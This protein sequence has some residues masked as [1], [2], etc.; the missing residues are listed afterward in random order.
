MKI[1]NFSLKGSIILKVVSLLLISSLLASCSHNKVIIAHRGA[2]GVLPEHTLQGV[3]M[4]HAWGVDFIEPDVVLSR[5]SEAIVLHDIYLESTTNVKE[6]FPKRARSDGHYYAIDFLLEEIKKLQVNERINPKTGLK[7]YPKRFPVKKSSFKVPTLKEYIELVQGLNK[8][9]GQNIGIYPEIKRPSFHKLEGKDITSIV[10]KI[11]S[12]YGYENGN[13]KIFVQCF[14][15]ETLKRI[16]KMKPNIPLVQLIGESSWF[17]NGVNYK[18]MQTREGLQKI[19]TYAQ[20][21]GPWI[22]HIYKKSRMGEGFDKTEL[23]KKAHEKGLVVHAYTLR[24][25]QIPPFAQNYK[26]LLKKVF[27]NA[28]V[29]GA[30]TDHV[31]ETKNILK[32]L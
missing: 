7:V 1:S 14:E 27:L 19:S 21:I 9:T 17:K 11:L 10:M 28:Q 15:P 3:A 12:H 8:S 31:L 16:R 6:L 20:G 26:D 29:D 4:A 32:E 30:F 24:R 13:D 23:V 18:E 5:D 25:D 2:S 22:G